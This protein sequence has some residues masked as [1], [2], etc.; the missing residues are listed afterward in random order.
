VIDGLKRDLWGEN[1]ELYFPVHEIH[2]TNNQKLHLEILLNE[3]DELK[4]V[5][6]RNKNI[7]RDISDI[8]L[9]YNNEIPYLSPEI[10]LLFKAK[11]TKKKDDADFR[12]VLRF[13]Q[14]TS[15][16]WLK[17]S[18]EICYPNHHWLGVLYKY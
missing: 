6:R 5:F 17:E 15:I 11:S 3:S 2:A 12:N 9:R 14:L 7:K 10:V 4:W 13:M 16:E 18:L 8:G 1:E